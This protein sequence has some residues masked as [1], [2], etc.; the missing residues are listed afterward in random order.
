[1][2][3]NAIYCKVLCDLETFV[4]TVCSVKLMYADTRVNDVHC[5][6]CAE[7]RKAFSHDIVVSGPLF[8]NVFCILVGFF[9]SYLQSM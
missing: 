1:M 2:R 5:L 4:L 9:L 7:S 3:K 6:L 8:L